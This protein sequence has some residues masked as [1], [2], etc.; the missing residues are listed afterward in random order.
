[1]NNIQSKPDSTT[2]NYIAIIILSILAFSGSAYL[3]FAAIVSPPF[4]VEL[5]MEFKTEDAVKC[6]AKELTNRNI[7]Y[8]II[9]HREKD[10]VV[11]RTIEDRNEL[12]PILANEC[13][14]FSQ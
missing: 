6:I 9:E 2:P 10:W 11:L 3:I 4:D 1:M 14:L 5:S 7:P 12:Q 8:E 13:A